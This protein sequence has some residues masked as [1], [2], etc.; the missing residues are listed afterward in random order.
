M[1]LTFQIG[2]IKMTKLIIGMEVA[3]SERLKGGVGCMRIA[4][5]RVKRTMKAARPSEVARSSASAPHRRLSGRHGAVYPVIGQ[6]TDLDFSKLFSHGRRAHRTI[7]I[8]PLTLKMKRR[9]RYEYRQ[10]PRR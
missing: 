4:Q 7:A 1:C 6:G 2:K 10:P 3:R 8:N 9:N 5:S